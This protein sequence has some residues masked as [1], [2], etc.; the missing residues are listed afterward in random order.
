M[1]TIENVWNIIKIKIN[2]N[3]MPC[4]EEEMW[5]PVCKGWYNVASN[6]LEELNTSMP[7]RITDLIKAKRGDTKKY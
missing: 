2:G 3:Q 1:S 7:R 6:G 4:K 5:R